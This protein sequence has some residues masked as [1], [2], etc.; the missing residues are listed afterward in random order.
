MEEL[1][2]LLKELG[3]SGSSCLSSTADGN[4]T[5]SWGGSES[6]KRPPKGARVASNSN[7]IPPRTPGQVGVVILI[8]QISKLGVGE[9]FLKLPFIKNFNF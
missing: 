7:C 4:Q 2:P 6:W 9:L 1:F 5:Q 8:S 3:V